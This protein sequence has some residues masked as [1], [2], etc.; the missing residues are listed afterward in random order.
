M[1]SNFLNEEAKRIA[2]NITKWRS[3]SPDHPPCAKCGKIIK[4]IPIRLT[5]LKENK[6]ITFHTKCG[7]DHEAVLIGDNEDQFEDNEPILIECR[8]CKNSK[9]QYWSEWH[10]A[11][12]I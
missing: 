10:G 9:C 5:N 12:Q 11:K 7:L 3:C 8:Y 1:S 4:D 2:N 6:E